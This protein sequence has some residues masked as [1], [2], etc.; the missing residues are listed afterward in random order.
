MNAGDI[1]ARIW[2]VLMGTQAGNLEGH[3]V[4]GGPGPQQGELSVILETGTSWQRVGVESR[5]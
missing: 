4:I 1:P 3:K 2:P 5:S